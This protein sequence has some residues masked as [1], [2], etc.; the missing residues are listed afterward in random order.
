MHERLLG[1][2]MQQS[3]QSKHDSHDTRISIDASSYDEICIN[4]G[5]RDT[6]GGWG[7]LAEEC[8]TPKLTSTK[9]II[10]D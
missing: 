6:L 4:C 7:K 9:E 5:A 10:N 2:Y 3:Q 1:G 8:P